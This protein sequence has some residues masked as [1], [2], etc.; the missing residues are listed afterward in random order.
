MVAPGELHSPHSSSATFDVERIRRDFPILTTQ[1][2]GRPLVYLDSAATAQRP[3]VVIDAVNRFYTEQNANVHRGVHYLSEV[4]TREFD[5]ARVKVQHFLNAAE[6]HEIILTHGVTESINLV[7]NSYG[8]KFIGAGDEILL[9]MME[10]HSNIVPWQLLA[11]RTGAKV[12]VIPINERG[13]VLLEE[14]EKMLNP[15]VKIVGVVHISNALGTINPVKQMIELAH[16]HGIPVLVDGAQA[17]PHLKVDVQELDCDFYAFSGHK[18]CGPTGVGVLY[19]KTS[20]LEAMP[21][22][23]GGGDMILSVSFEKTT[24]NSLPYKFEAGTP[25][26]AGVIGLGAAI[27]YLH[28]TRLDR[29][30][31]YE[32]ELL[33]YATEQVG[34]LSG[35]KLIGTAAEKAG[36][37]SFVID[38]IHPHDIGTILDQEGVAIRAGHHCAQPALKFFGVP[39]TARASFAFYNTRAE[40][41]ALV[42][43]IDKVK[44]VFE[45]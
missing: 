15:R 2:K 36:V 10:H 3:Q 43:A 31:A 1:V 9:T 44:Q 6:S 17:T 35:I 7:A 22:F 45:I 14:Y 32:K 18:L 39:A 24:F 12:R 13:E 29:I 11:E 27:D 4:A 28:R 21:P 5:G 25:D 40:V 30:A 34:A 26:I 38:E 41:D 19:G 20:W 33:D 37:L 8:S 16:R 23:L 42:A